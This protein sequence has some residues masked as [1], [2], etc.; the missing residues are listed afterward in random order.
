MSNETLRSATVA[1]SVTTPDAPP[2]TLGKYQLKGEI[3]R[4]TCGVVY[5]G[6]DPFVQRYVAV[7]VARTGVNA[8]TSAAAT[9]TGKSIPGQNSTGDASK[10]FFA[11]ARA[12][13]MLQ[14]PHI[15][16]LFD[17]GIEEGYSYLVMEYVEGDTLM[18]LCHKKTERVP[19]EKVVDI[20]FKCAKALDYAHEKSVLHRDI[21][22][23]NIMITSAGV[24]KIMDFS[25]AEIDNEPIA[26]G[27]L[28]SP[29]YMAP[30]HVK[31]L[32]LGP[33]SDLYSLGAVMYHLLTGEPPFVADDVQQLF[34]DIVRKPAPNVRVLRPDCPPQL[35]EVVQNL[36]LKDPAER[37][38]TGKRLAT[39]LSRLFDQLRQTENQITRREQ[40]D[41]LRRLHFFNGF[42]NEEIDE[43]LNASAM[44]TFEAG[45]TIIA[46]GDIDNA[47]YILVLGTAQ[48]M[49]GE[50]PLHTMQ[51]GDCFGEIG[52]FSAAKRMTAVVA[53]T[54]LLALKVSETQLEQTS[55]RCQLRFY[56]TFTET[57]IYRLSL[58]SMKLS[59]FQ[60]GALR[61]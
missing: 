40:G 57:L 20:A 60:S 4:G 33:Q 14:H 54:K 51:K 44:R 28:G 7:K 13:G 50:Q 36:L 29:S 45:Q 46:E 15:V 24:P 3:G 41:S 43:L 27:I 32:P 48:V 39:A 58:A 1:A 18:P 17:A 31:Q 49:K 59:T 8:L 11:E 19:F 53:A 23:S 22:P 21:K 47:F 34:K 25:I 16:S 2:K 37:Y 52:M 5:K 12:A 6:F 30:E 9:L 38:P 55:L 35:A 42:S 56:K 61:P 10:S 26:E